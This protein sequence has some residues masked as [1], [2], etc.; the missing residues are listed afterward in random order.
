MEIATVVL[1]I[2]NIFLEPITRQLGY[3][4]K[5]QEKV[6]ELRNK[7]E[8]LKVRILDLEANIEAAERS[9]KAATS[10]AQQWFNRAR[11]LERE[12]DE[13]VER[14]NENKCC[15]GGLCPNCTSNYKSG[16]RATTK[17][18]QITTH[19]N[20]TNTV[21]WSMDRPPPV[22]REMPTASIT[23]QST[24][25]KNVNTILE[26][27]SNDELGVIGIN[28]MGGVGKTTVM[29]EINN[30]LSQN[31]EFK[32]VIWITVS[33]DVNITRIQKEIMTKLGMNV[34]D[35][36]MIAE[37]LFFALK[38]QRFLLILD[39]L[40]EK[41]DLNA[42][43][44]PRPNPQNKCKII[45]TTRSLMVCNR[46]ETDLKIKVDVLIEEEAWILF[47]EK[48]RNVVSLP[49][50]EPI[51]RKVLKE[52]GG[53]PLAIIVVGCAMR[54]KDNVHVWE[55]ALRALR[56]A[57]MEIKG[58]EREVFVPLKYSYDQ[59]QD[60]NIR[61][62]FLYCSLF[63]EDYE[64]EKNNLA[65]RWMCEGLLGRVDSVEDARNK[66]H[67]LIEK[68]IDSCMI[69]QVPG[70]D[71][72]VKLHDVIR[73]V[74][75][76]IGSTREGGGFI[77][78]AGLGLK[79]ALRV[80]EWGEA[81][82]ISLMRNE[83]ERLPNRPVCLVLTT[84]ILR[85]N[86]NLNNIP[87]GFFE[88]L[89]AL[90][91]LDLYGTGINS[92]PQ[93]LSN[94]KDLRY[95]SLYD[96]ENLVDIPHVGQLQQLQVLDLCNTKI[97]RLPEGMGE[98]AN[99]KLLNLRKTRDLKSIKHG[100][101][102]RLSCLEELNTMSSGYVDWK[103]IGR[104]EI[105]TEEACWEEFE[106]LESLSS[107]RISIY[108]NGPFFNKKQWD[109][110]IFDKIEALE[111]VGCQVLT[112]LE[113][114]P[115]MKRLDE[116]FIKNCSQLDFVGLDV[117]PSLKRLECL[118][119]LDLRVVRRIW[120][121]DGDRHLLNLRY[122]TIEGCDALKNV[123]LA[124]VVQC[125]PCLEK[126]KIRWCSGLEEIISG[127]QVGQNITLPKLKELKLYDLVK[128]RSICEI[129]ITW[130][131]LVRIF[132]RGCPELK[133]LPLGLREA[134]MLRLIEGEKEWWA[135]LEWEDDRT[136]STL[137]PLFVR[138]SVAKWE[139]LQLH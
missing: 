93:S 24:F 14:Y 71:S 100:V 39:D 67:G 113:Q 103:T 12:A 76:R 121:G 3:L 18:S 125:L 44:V 111:V 98:L 4:F 102:S 77:V 109:R 69:E 110:K 117:V 107:L 17:L 138:T 112:S 134:E 116:L 16:R 78:E 91:V 135:G 30:R 27:L 41:L 104:E 106:E 56:E 136:N 32:R 120:K 75:I 88:C 108:G 61:Q 64:I 133:R 36:Y 58:M 62:C 115:P 48:A 65:G 105:S 2:L 72:Y 86:I 1:Q 85:E 23:G 95:L 90:K 19:I 45:I 99:L 26:C 130:P 126:M 51:A 70:W 82:R 42:I 122:F 57:T 29:L 129:A 50:I 8:R 53:L 6:E 68:L 37:R 20:L 31:R 43:G 54:D 118:R 28:G 11:E 139:W 73:D 13:V 40:W 131:S 35:E 38:E 33:K 66:G 10:E 74:A 94:L 25:D 124:N 132:V 81:Q 119:L 97:K 83:I 47:R 123:L 59:L 34:E 9:G 52:C 89:E 80:E 114:L 96:C 87:E 7:N 15:F 92:L 21:N 127:G 60:E 101:I 46:M 63:P 137:L 22:G 128:L 79:E 49:S 5:C 55:N 84:L